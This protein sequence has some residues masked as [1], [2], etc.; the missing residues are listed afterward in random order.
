MAIVTNHAPGPRGFNVKN[1]AGDFEQ[2]L[3][4]PNETRE[5]DLSGAGHPVLAGMIR[6]G[7][8]VIEP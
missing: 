2:V 8:L 5:L 3:L 6:N 1:E 7:E 4:Q